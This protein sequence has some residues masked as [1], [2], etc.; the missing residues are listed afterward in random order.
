MRVR[1]KTLNTQKQF[2]RNDSGSSRSIPVTLKAQKYIKEP[3][4]S[5]T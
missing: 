5:L 4:R 3:D 1:G 2:S